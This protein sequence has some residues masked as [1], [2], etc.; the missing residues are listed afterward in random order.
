MPCPKCFL[1]DGEKIMK[2]PT[3][4]IKCLYR[5]LYLGPLEY[6][7][8][9]LITTAMFGGE[10]SVDHSSIEGVKVNFKEHQTKRSWLFHGVTG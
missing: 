10:A 8:R 1:G 7:A 6:E 5:V 4:N 2:I 9:V 3:K